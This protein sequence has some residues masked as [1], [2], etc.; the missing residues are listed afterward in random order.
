MPLTKHQLGLLREIGDNKIALDET[1]SDWMREQLADLI[2]HSPKLIDTVGPSV[3]L[4]AA[5]SSL[6]SGLKNQAAALTPDKRREE[7]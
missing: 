7:T 6:I 4:T 5:G 2:F 3:F 1:M